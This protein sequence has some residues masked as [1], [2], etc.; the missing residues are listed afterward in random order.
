M[1]SAGTEY[2]TVVVSAAEGGWILKRKHFPDK[3]FIRWESLV[4]ELKKILSS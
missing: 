2:E 4:I 1:K 3:V